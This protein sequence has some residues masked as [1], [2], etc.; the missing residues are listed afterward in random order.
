MILTS[1]LLSFSIVKKCLFSTCFVRI[2]VRLSVGKKHSVCLINNFKHA[3]YV[4]NI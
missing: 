2:P 1:S 3:D 4:N